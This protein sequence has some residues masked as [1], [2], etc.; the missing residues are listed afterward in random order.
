MWNPADKHIVKIRIGSLYDPMCIK[1]KNRQNSTVVF[2]I[3]SVCRF[4]LF[5]MNLASVYLPN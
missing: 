3:A 5:L 4:L 1:F 2:L